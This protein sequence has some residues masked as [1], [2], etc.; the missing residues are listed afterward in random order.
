MSLLGVGLPLLTRL[1]RSPV[2]IFSIEQAQPRSRSTLRGAVTANWGNFRA[3]MPRVGGI[4]S[5]KSEPSV[6]QEGRPERWKGR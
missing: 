4:L 6:P 3:F 5:S 1:G 2:R